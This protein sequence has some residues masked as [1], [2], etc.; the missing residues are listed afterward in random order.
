MSFRPAFWTGGIQPTPRRSVSNAQAEGHRWDWVAVLTQKGPS[1]G[2]GPP[3][4]Y[5]LIPTLPLAHQQSAFYPPY[6]RSHPSSLRESN[7]DRGQPQPSAVYPP[8]PRS[9]PSSLRE[10][11]PD[12]GQPQPCAFYPHSALEPYSTRHVLRAREVRVPHMAAVTRGVVASVPAAV[13]VAHDPAERAKR[14][15]WEFEEAREAEARRWL[16]NL[17]GEMDAGSWTPTMPLHAAQRPYGPGVC[18]ARANE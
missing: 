4:P 7:P 8:Y 13:E 2:R 15:E 9:H 10:S 18:G 17:A 5:T 14:R 16:P 1:R 11:N 6:P 12:R 3:P